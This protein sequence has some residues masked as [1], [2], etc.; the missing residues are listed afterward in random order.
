M[1]AAPAN[2][3]DALEALA[4]AAL[5]ADARLDPADTLFMSDAE[6]IAEGMRRTGVPRFAGVEAGG[7]VVLGSIRIDQAGHFAWASFDYRWLAGD[8]D[9][10]HEGRATLVFTRVAA[11]EGS[12]W[13][14]AHL[15]SS[16]QQ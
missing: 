2:D 10:F 13:R 4:T 14:I 1:Q 5:K 3:T 6:V 11:A 15:H 16:L 7:Q 9:Q 12:A 8:R